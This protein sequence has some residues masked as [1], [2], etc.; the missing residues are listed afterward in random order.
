MILLSQISPDQRP[1]DKYEMRYGTR[2]AHQES[3]RMPRRSAAR[4]KPGRIIM[5][6]FCDWTVCCNVYKPRNA[7]V[8]LRVIL[9]SQIS[10]DQRP[11][12]KYEMR[13]GTRGAHQE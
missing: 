4:Q 1:I 12:D 13:Y 3:Y 8:E 6:H 10:P 5:R 7:L 9:L 11:I 2:G